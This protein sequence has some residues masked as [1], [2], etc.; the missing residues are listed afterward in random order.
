M[1]FTEQEERLHDE[2]RRAWEAGKALLDAA[3]AENR[4]LTAEESEQFERISSE[5]DAYAARAERIATVARQGAIIEEFRGSYEAAPSADERPDEWRQFLNGER[6]TYEV[7]LRAA[8]EA[9]ALAS[10]SSPAVF[11]DITGQLWLHL[12]ETATVAGISTVITTSKGNPMPVPTTTGD[13]TGSQV[14][15]GVA[16]SPTD[17]TL[18]TRTLGS[19][20]YK[21]L[22][23]VSTQLLQDEAFDVEGLIAT[24]AGRAVGNALGAALVTGNGSTAPGGVSTLSSLGKTGSASVAG[25]F[26]ADDLIDLY[27]SV[28]APY[29]NSPKAAWLMRDATL[30][31]VRKLKT[32]GSGE[33]LFAPAAT[34]GAPDTILG[35]PVYTD[36]N[37][38]AVGLSGKS[39]LF[40]DFG[41]YCTR[42]VNGVRFERSDDYRFNT[43]EVAFRTVLS[44]DGTL[45][46]Q[47]GAVKHF[48]GN[49]A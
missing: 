7:P 30:A 47:T 43:D 27:F 14:A 24:Q 17:P 39:V 42:V 12:I 33:Y 19:Y 6:R 11:Q 3:E 28:I 49:A 21:S 15:E 18:A 4:D 37:V 23:Y 1:S 34:V 26:S 44:A 2:R 38:A 35:K 25:A 41:A 36:P 40:G 45:V 31:A 13:P 5:M 46:D 20:D 9:R 29:R 16:I 8:I 32:S 22:T 10:T 48:I